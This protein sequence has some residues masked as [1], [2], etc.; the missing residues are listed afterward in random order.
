MS[1]ISTLLVWPLLTVEVSP[2]KAE[3]T[4]T[5]AN[6]MRDCVPVKKASQRKRLRKDCSTVE[7]T[8]IVR[9]DDVSLLPVSHV[10][11][12]LKTPW[13]FTRSTRRERVLGG[14]WF[15]PE[16]GS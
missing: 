8:W 6:K 9:R 10:D 1:G 12:R 2:L 16:G 11:R 14:W 13:A 7:N 15:P 5:E 3:P 4:E